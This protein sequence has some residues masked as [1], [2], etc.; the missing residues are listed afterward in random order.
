MKFSKDKK[1]KKVYKTNYD[2]IV[3]TLHFTMVFFRNFANFV[4]A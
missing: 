1:E 4:K 3:V 2:L